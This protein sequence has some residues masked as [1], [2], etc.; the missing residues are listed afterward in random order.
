[1]RPS[2]QLD[3]GPRRGL[4]LAA[5]LAAAVV[6]AACGSSRPVTRYEVWNWSVAIPDDL[7]VLPAVT[8]PD[9]I[10]ATGPL[11][12]TSE[13]VA[14]RTLHIRVQDQAEGSEG[15]TA[16]S[17]LQ[18]VTDEAD[19]EEKGPVTPHR[20]PAGAGAMVHAVRLGLDLDVIYIVAR[21]QLVSIT[22]SEMT[23]ADV[24]FIADSFAFRD[25]PGDPL[26]P[27]SRAPT[28]AP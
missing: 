12:I 25:P 2:L 17:I 10:W 24:Q 23:P 14:G 7:N 26:H 27:P 8:D 28:A 4:V 3:V 6:A 18:A 1:M 5:T 22:A 13:D 16:L 9:T 15:E 20:F 21:G 19:A 11:F